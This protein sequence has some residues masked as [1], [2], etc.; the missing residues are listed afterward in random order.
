MRQRFSV[1]S[2]IHLCILI[3]C[4]KISVSFSYKNIIQKYQINYKI[5][6]L[7][8]GDSESV[9]EKGHS[10]ENNERTKL[11]EKKKLD[12]NAKEN[13]KNEKNKADPNAKGKKIDEKNKID[14]NA[15]DKK[16][17]EKNKIDPNAKENKKN[18]KNKADPNSKEN[19]IDEM[20]KE[21]SK[22]PKKPKQLPWWC[23]IIAYGLSY[24]FAGISI[25]FIILK[26]ISFGNDSCTKWLTSVLIS[27]FSS[28]LIT[29]SIQVFN[30]R[31]IFYF[32]K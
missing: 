32:S 14:P 1:F 17:D 2:F 3:R 15:K 9:N 26:G 13:K 19:K 11:N 23:K 25:F 12:P 24:L 7:A 28:V 31:I 4:F 18:E 27:L 8:E 10:K 16:I 21:V 22:L 5:Y 29:Q 30:F 20:N 6:R